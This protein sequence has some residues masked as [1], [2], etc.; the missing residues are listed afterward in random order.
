M[1][2]KGAVVVGGEGGIDPAGAAGSGESA[3]GGGLGD[4]LWLYGLA[5]GLAAALCSPLAYS[6]LTSDAPDES[7]TGSEGSTAGLARTR[8]QH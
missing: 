5:G 3:G 4:D 2:M 7:T 8:R 6:A 1:G